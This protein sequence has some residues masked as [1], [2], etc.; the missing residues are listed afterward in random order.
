MLRRFGRFLLWALLACGGAFAVF[1]GYAFY[2]E[3]NAEK[4]AIAFCGSTKLGDDP[5]DVLERARKTDAS[6]SH[7]RWTGEVDGSRTLSV[8]FVGAPPFSRHIC[9]V[10]AGSRVSATKYV[11]LD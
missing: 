10:R 9:E 2:A 3:P 8:I 5:A 7:L 6:K 1:V 4:L 11:Y